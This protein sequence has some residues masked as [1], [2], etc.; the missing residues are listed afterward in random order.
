MFPLRTYERGLPLVFL[1]FALVLSQPLLSHAEDIDLESFLDDEDVAA[2]I[3]DPLEPVNRVFFAFNDS[4]YFW[5]VKPVGKVYSSVLAKDVRTC[6]SAAFHNILA[7]VRVVNHLLQ[8][9]LQD[10]GTELARFMINTTLGAGGLGDPAGEEFGI[11]RSDADFGQTL[12]KYGVGTGLYICWPIIGPSSAR[13]SVGLVGDYSLNPLTYGL[14]GQGELAL[15]L[16]MLKYENEATLHGEQYESMVRKAFDPYVSMRDIYAQYRRGV[17]ENSGSRTLKR[18]DPFR[19]DE[20][21][22]GFVYGER[23]ANR[24]KARH[25]EQCRG[26]AGGEGQ[27]VRYT[28]AGKVY[29]GVGF[30]DRY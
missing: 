23:Y 7:P 8:W 21:C 24:I 30:P 26:V 11:M 16:Y 1:L 29:Y 27:L 10:S 9:E 13:D 4:M 28:E 18:P 14:Q 15:E 20:D 12:G 22:P 17:I 3:A 25:H 5:V 19:P 2:A 6:I